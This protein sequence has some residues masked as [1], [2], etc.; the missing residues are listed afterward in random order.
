MA[1]GNQLD[2]DEIERKLRE[3][4]EQIGRP[5][6]HEPT[7]LERLVAAKKTERKAQRKKDTGVLA[8]LAVVFVLLAGGGIFTWLRLAP[9]S[10]LHASARTSPSAAPT[11]KVKLTTTP[12]SP[13][14]SNGPP[15][16][17]FSGSPSD[18]WADG[19]A[20][21]A[22]PAAK[23]H[24]RYTAAQVRS[25]YEKTGKLL[26]AGNLNWPTLR[27]GAPTAFADLLTKPERKDFLAGL[28]AT[29]LNKDGSEKNTRT[30]VAS[31]SPGST[32]FV[33]T[34]IKVHGKMS[35]GIATS[36]GIEVLRVKV[37]YLF[38]FAVEPPGKPADWTRI[39]Q[40][41]Y[42]YVD[43]AQWDDPGGALEPWITVSSETAGGMCD[44]RDGYIHP[45]FPQGAPDSVKPSGTAQDPYSLAT[46][47]AAD[48]FS[49]H[50]VT[51]T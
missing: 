49:C 28:H 17:P 11:P 23:A 8:A 39:I 5:P 3:L 30:W 27:G 36:D 41:R 21:I 24:G 46:P 31:F 29:A 6:V 12:V 40:Q 7:P 43:F 26:A 37:D 48:Q 25:A 47:S 9:P 10:W 35:A 14:T 33:T 1:G 18:A 16:D 15:A 42:G 38:V 22:I 2:P 4:N 13:V 32:Q 34:V 45:D 44:S 51:R 20:G 19:P 50:P